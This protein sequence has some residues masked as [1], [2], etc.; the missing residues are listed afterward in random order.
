MKH[1]PIINTLEPTRILEISHFD[2]EAERGTWRRE[3]VIFRDNV[4]INL[5]IEGDVSVFTDGMTHSP[6]FG[7]IC[8]LAPMKMHCGS[9]QKN[10]HLVYFQL[11]V[12]VNALDGIPEGARLINDIVE[13][14]RKKPSFIRPHEKERDTVIHL[15]YSIASACREKNL[16]LAFAE[17][18]KLL[19][20]L[21]N[22]YRTDGRPASYAPSKY[23]RLAIKYLEERYSDNV[24][25]SSLAKVLKV[26]ESYVSRIFR[27]ETGSS[28]HEY[29]TRYRITKA[30]ELLSTLSVAEVG[31]ACGFSDSSHFISTF[32]R[33][34]GVT[35]MKYK[36]TN[37]F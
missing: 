35:P 7:D 3:D 20:T 17:A 34:M 9:I 30:S 2:F 1:F 22:I 11:D 10:T 13:I 16:A 33:Y 26:S 24:T 32:K 6:A 21:R 15:F 27:R 36:Q 29:L 4:K 8:M 31:Y 5:F 12:G 25:V 37:N 14:L 18:I 19:D 23:T 28:P